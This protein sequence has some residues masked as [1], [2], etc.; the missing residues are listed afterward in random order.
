MAATIKPIEGRSIHLIQSGQVIVD[1]CSVV[2]ELV[3]NS[4]DA[5]ATIIDVRFKNQGLDLVEVQDNGSGICPANYPSIALKHHTSKLSS[6]SDIASLRTFGFRG[7]ALASLCALSSVTIT[8]CLESEVPRGCKLGF[9]IS[10][11]LASTTMVASQRGTTVSVEKL[12]HN[13]P[14]RRRELERNIKREWHKVIALLNQYACVQTNLKFSV[15]QQPTKGKRIILFSTKSN[16]TTRENIINIFGSKAM[17]TLVSLDLL[18]EMHPSNVGPDLRTDQESKQVRILGHVS[19]PVHGDG[20]QAP[21]R[22]MFFVNGRPCGLPQFAKTFNEVYKAYNISQSPFIFADVQLD[23]KMYDVNVSPDKRSIL[24]HDQS[25]LLDRL[26][27]SLIRLFDSHDYQ[28]PTTQVLITETPSCPASVDA[29]RRS[30]PLI[31]ENPPYTSESELSATSHG[32]PD[33]GSPSNTGF[34]KGK[35]SQLAMREEKI[36]SGGRE[37]AKIAPESLTKWFGCD[38]NRP[39]ISNSASQNTHV[40]QNRPSL[41]LFASSRTIALTDSDTEQTP[42]SQSLRRVDPIADTAPRNTTVV[43]HGTNS[44][45]PSEA[46]SDS[47]S[48]TAFSWNAISS[49]P[50]TSLVQTI[51]HGDTVLL[52]Q[53]KKPHKGAVPQTSENSHSSHLPNSGHTGKVCSFS[54]FQERNAQH[55]CSGCSSDPE[56]TGDTILDDKLSSSNTKAELSEASTLHPKG[57]AKDN[58]ENL[59]GA[60]CVTPHSNQPQIEEDEHIDRSISD[61]ND[62]DNVAQGDTNGRPHANS[63]AARRTRALGDGLR[64]KFGTAQHSQIIRATEATLASLSSS[65]LAYSVRNISGPVEE[66]VADI[67]ASDAESKLPLIIAKDDFSEMRVVGQFNLGFIIAVRPKSHRHTCHEANDADELFIIDQHASDE[68][69]NFERL[70]LNTV[71]QSQRLVYP[72]ALQLTALEEEIVLGNLSALEANGFKIQVDSTGGSPVGARCQLLALPLSREVA[73]TLNDLEELITL[74]AEESSGSRHIPRPS[75]VRKMFAMRACRSSIMIGKPLT[76]SQMYSLVR[77]MGELDKPWN[78]PHGRPTMRHLCSL[79]AWDKAKW[80]AD[81]HGNSTT[82]SWLAYSMD[83]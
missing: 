82:E 39:P 81:L 30:I 41:S 37:G 8:T 74:L 73:F 64:K 58:T 24:L 1:L 46:V 3:E 33:G 18:L 65:W 48:P 59:G 16:P 15:S 6:Y 26:R 52:I 10:G 17:S 40:K 11:K 31:R 7:E 21:D 66:R 76:T 49:G 62:E 63:S 47:R 20:R 23:T 78:C 35:S 61:S 28:L 70:Q 67:T 22:Q 25:L 5:G 51:G 27:S 2:K 56:S 12:F 43:D 32:E 83:N 4:I 19:R 44:H 42:Q 14:V 29:N 69:F 50:S 71:I 34:V 79:L 54:E 80:V 60:R 75:R 9:E 72:K 36:A 53:K 45:K 68:K 57:M 77:H 38:A 13:L 55:S